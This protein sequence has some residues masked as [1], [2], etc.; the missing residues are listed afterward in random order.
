CHYECDCRVNLLIRAG[1]GRVKVAASIGLAHHIANAP[2]ED[3]V[4]LVAQSA[5]AHCC[6][7]FDNRRLKFCVVA[8]NSCIG[9]PSALNRCDIWADCQ[10]SYPALITLNRL[11]SCRTSLS[12]SSKSVSLPDVTTSWPAAAQ[13]GYD[14]FRASATAASFR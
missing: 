9:T 3:R 12:I 10:G 11:H 6:V 13:P 4:P 5:R 1:F 8:R 14:G 2:R 7:E